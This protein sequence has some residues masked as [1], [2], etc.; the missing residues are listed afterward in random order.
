MNP[1]TIRD[2]RWAHFTEQLY[3]AGCVQPNSS[4]WDA[5]EAL[6]HLKNSMWKAHDYVS[7]LRQEEIIVQPRR[8]DE[9]M[10]AVMMRALRARERNNRKTL[11]AIHRE[12]PEMD[13]IAPM[14]SSIDDPQ[15]IQSLRGRIVDMAKLQL[16]D[17]MRRISRA[18]DDKKQ[19]LQN[20]VNRRMAPLCPKKNTGLRAVV[21]AQGDVHTTTHAMS[22]VLNTYWAKIFTQQDRNLPA[23]NRWCD[24]IRRRGTH[25]W[26]DRQWEVSESHVRRAI[27]NSNNSCP[28]PDGIPYCAFRATCAISAPCLLNVVI[29]LSNGTQHSRHKAGSGFNESTICYLPK[30]PVGQTNGEDVYDPAGTRPLNLSNVDNRLIAASCRLAWEK[31]FDLVIHK[32]QRGFV[33][34]RSMTANI[35]DIE[36]LSRTTAASSSNGALILWDLA[37]AFPSVDRMFMA[38]TLEAMGVPSTARALINNLYEGTHSMYTAQGMKF[39]AFEST[40]GI[41]Q[42]CP[43]SPLIFS[44]VTSEFLA[45]LSELPGVHPRSYADDTAT[46]VEHWDSRCQ[47]SGTPSWNTAL[48][49]A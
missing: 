13:N 31:H 33:R 3:H 36:R 4:S 24:K 39:S 41:R 9:D 46:V 42:G 45:Q 23:I 2:P 6:E 22:E 32:W 34:G 11:T 43:L 8:A 17:D 10:V 47:A 30:K 40:R 37:A 1:S 26:T 21:D 28:G 35:V 44:A 7:H 19:D 14:T 18:P 27:V 16:V 12:H 25:T 5:W 29:A 48:P 49:P 15:T 20:R 38:K